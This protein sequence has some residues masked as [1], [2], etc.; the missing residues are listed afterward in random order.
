MGAVPMAG[1]LRNIADVIAEAYR[2]VAPE[3][4]DDAGEVAAQE[5]AKYIR[6][7]LGFE[8]DQ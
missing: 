3:D 7:E 2:M 1:H 6:D 8:V 5:V 4:Y